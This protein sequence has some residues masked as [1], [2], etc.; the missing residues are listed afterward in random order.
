[1]Y[2]LS[3]VNAGPIVFGTGGTSTVI[4]AGA[5]GTSNPINLPR[6]PFTLQV[7]NQTTGTSILAGVAVLQASN[8]SVGWIPISTVTALTTNAATTTG[9]GA[10]GAAI[11]NQPYAYGRVILSGTG[12]GQ[13][14]AFFGA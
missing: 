2:D 12:T 3:K 8:D 13:S 14:T 1:M 6:G 4:A 7:T 10:A 5:V 9:V 11:S